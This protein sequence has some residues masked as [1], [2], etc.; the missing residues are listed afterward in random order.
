[1]IAIHRT[2]ST[3]SHEPKRAGPDL[4][5]I[6]FLNVVRH[7]SSDAQDGL[8]A[9]DLK[10]DAPNNTEPGSSLDQLGQEGP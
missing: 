4:V 6:V 8:A 9:G 2:C 5:P 1:M 7:G 10:I 3:A